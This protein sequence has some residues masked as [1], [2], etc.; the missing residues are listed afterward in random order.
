MSFFEKV[1]K[2]IT[3]VGQSAAKQTKNLTEIV[4][5]NVAISEK[6]KRIKEC[7]YTIGLNFYATHKDDPSSEEF[8]LISEINLLNTQITDCRG[9]I[10]QIKGFSKCPNCGEDVPNGSAFCASCGAKME[11]D[12]IKTC[13]QCGASYDGKTVFCVSCGTKLRDSTD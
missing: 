8:D 2:S 11:R 3:D 9:Q 13:P 6:E 12:E 4:K 5:L 10:K 1:G 7:C